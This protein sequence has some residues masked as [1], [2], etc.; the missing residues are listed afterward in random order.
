ME[1][2]KH[3]KE[4]FREYLKFV[5]YNEAQVEAIG[6]RFIGQQANKRDYLLFQQYIYGKEFKNLY[7]E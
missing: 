6:E 2:L 7:D 1:V 4:T 3:N 5:G